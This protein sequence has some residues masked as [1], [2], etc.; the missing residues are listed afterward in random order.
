V[1]YRITTF[2]STNSIT[3]PRVMDVGS[4]PVVIGASWARPSLSRAA[5]SQARSVASHSASSVGKWGPF[6]S[7]STPFSERWW[8]GGK[9]WTSMPLPARRCTALHPGPTPS[10]SRRSLSSVIS[11]RAPT[12]DAHF[13]A[14]PTRTRG[15]TREIIP[16]LHCVPHPPPPIGRVPQRSA[17]VGAAC[18]AVDAVLTH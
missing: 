5:A 13:H 8:R 17:S 2:A 7:A 15:M 14:S 11:P 6:T 3:K 10:S 9:K 18:P 1:R 16:L 12:I 4:P